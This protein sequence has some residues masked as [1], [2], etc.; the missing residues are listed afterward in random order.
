MKIASTFLLTLLLGALSVCLIGGALLLWPEWVKD[1]FNIGP[2]STTGI[3]IISL[4]LMLAALI[5][6]WVLETVFAKNGDKQGKLD[7]VA[8]GQQAAAS[9]PEAKHTDADT[10]RFVAEALVDHL[11]LRYR[12]RWKAKVRLLLVQGTDSDIEKVV[13][14]LK[15]D[16]WQE[17]DGIVIIYGGL[18]ESVPDDEFLSVLKAVRPQRPLDGVVQVMNTAALP[19][20]AKQDTLVRVRQKTDTQLGW[21]LPV[22]LWLVRE[23][24]WDQDGVG[25][26]P[27]G[28][29]FG[30][31]ATTEEV[32]ST[33]TSL[34]SDLQTPG[35]SAL[36]ENSQHHWL[37]SLS[38]ALRG[39]LRRSL[40]PLLTTLM[41][42][43]APYRLRGVMFSPALPGTETV[44]HA[45]L[46]PP[47]WQ[48]LEND[49]LQVHARKIGFH[50]QKVLRLVLLGLV[51]LWGAG[52][53]MSLSVN[54]TQIWLAQD[55]VRIAADT[56]QPLS[57]RLRNQLALQQTI[58]RLQN[59][60]V[61]GAPWYTR[62]GLNQ[63]SDT[64]KLLWPLYARNNQALMRD[65]LADELH[66]QL[67]AFVQLPP[68]S[69]ARTSATQKTYGLLKGYLMLARPDKADAEWLAGNM[70]KAWPQRSGVPDSVWQTQA[71][72]LLGFWAQNLPAHPEWK[73]SPDRELV[74][75]V[76]QILLKQ[77]GQRNAE[78]GLY[79]EMLGRIAR[80]WP[81]LTLS[82]MTGDTDASPVTT[83]LW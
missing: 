46:S 27:A 80:N 61:H 44:P 12:R 30:P 41:S 37:L 70:L 18:A 16:H 55:T 68:A 25:V 42:G 78:S 22:W 72:K 20:T 15:G 13:P 57:D 24:S 83:A 52:T 29:L 56:K 19:D 65:A 66:R 45:R 50:W 7:V 47:V 49:S 31:G 21:Q 23:G 9:Q 53:L 10:S 34:S 73:I 77:I 32:R 58:A 17:S 6:G 28:A 59:R 2:F 48:A 82:D 11:R 64:L 3:V 63:D 5:I 33:L 69:D 35:V 40:I 26:P 39:S 76:R 81:D 60:E 79:Q 67:N 51:L 74:G 62:F 54:R 36:L 38:K 75:T 71:P 43:P 8:S 4:L 14:G 1:T